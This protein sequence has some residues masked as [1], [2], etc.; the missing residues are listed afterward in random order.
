MCLDSPSFVLTP[1]DF[2]ACVLLFAA[3]V[4]VVR[5]VVV[6]VVVVVVRF[7]LHPLLFVIEC[8]CAFA[9]FSFLSRLRFFCFS[10]CR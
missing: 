9:V 6:V 7:C 1:L 10:D 2:C 8:P 4:V 3:V 5:V